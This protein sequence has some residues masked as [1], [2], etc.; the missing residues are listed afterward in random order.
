MKTL[1]GVGVGP[2]DPDLLTLKAIKVI[3][4]ADYVFVP[5]P[6]PDKQG[7]AEAIAAEYL[8]GKRVITLHFP[9]GP[10]NVDLYKRTAETLDRTLKDGESGAFITIGDPM[11]YSTFTYV[12]FEAQN[13]D[14]Q[15]VLVPGIS[16]CN[17]TAAALQMPVTIKGESF[18]LADGSV[19][20]EV[21]RRVQSV[22]VL[23]PR[24]QSA[25]T[26]EKLEKYGFEYRYIKRCSFPDQEIWC[27]RRAIEEDRDYMS[28][29]FSRKRG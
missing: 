22:C 3:R 2:G 24:K 16:T 18:Y 1:Y 15:C 7:M 20:E 17:A 26:L 6:K 19:D 4:S 11:T 27:D 8:Q 23:K 12:M 25:E 14:M 13:L 5:R 29:L 9:M 28:A 10:D 21:L